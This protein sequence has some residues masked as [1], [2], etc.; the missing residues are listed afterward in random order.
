M[1][2]HS[3]HFY[4]LLNW[5]PESIRYIKRSWCFRN[6]ILIEVLEFPEDFL[7]P[8]P[9]CKGNHL[10]SAFPSSGCPLGLGGEGR[11]VSCGSWCHWKQRGCANP[12]RWEPWENK[13]SLTT[14]LTN[15]KGEKNALKQVAGSTNTAR[16]MLC[17]SQLSS[18]TMGPPL[19]T[20]MCPGRL[21]APLCHPLCACSAQASWV[22]VT[23]PGHSSVSWA[24]ALQYVIPAHACAS[25]L[26]ASSAQTEGLTREL[27]G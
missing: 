12:G 13:T 11:T 16:R 22:Q 7:L 26:C 20:R 21:P 17:S 1:Q 3:I 9:I 4:T 19:W 14:L 15:Q 25:G 5:A 24:T 10:G 8:P 23:A 18:D 6:R 2:G 27:F